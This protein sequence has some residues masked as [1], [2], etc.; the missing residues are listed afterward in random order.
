M[1]SSN[2]G[3]V[4]RRMPRSRTALS[5]MRSPPPG[6]L[7]FCGINSSPLTMPRPGPCW[8]TSDRRSFRQ[9]I[10][11]SLRN[12]CHRRPSFLNYAAIQ[13]GTTDAEPQSF[14]LAHLCSWFISSPSLARVA[15]EPHGRR[16]Y[17]AS[18]TTLPSSSSLAVISSTALCMPRVVRLNP[19][20]LQTPAGMA[21]RDIP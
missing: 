9:S 2:C 15:C 13:R 6:V 4:M 20:K 18:S 8:P 7:A 12:C 14:L 3:P 5:T 16:M 17:V 1:S 10:R 19:N 21:S 11:Y